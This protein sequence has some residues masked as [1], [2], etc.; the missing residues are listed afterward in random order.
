ME[1]EVFRIAP[2]APAKRDMP[3]TPVVITKLQHNA[4]DLLDASKSVAHDGAGA[5]SHFVGTTRD[6]FE[7]KRVLSLE[8]EAYDKMAVKEMERL[9]AAILAQWPDLKGIYIAHR[10]GSVPVGEASVIIAVSSP[11][12]RSAIGTSIAH[13]FSSQGSFSASLYNRIR[14]SQDVLTATNA[15]GMNSEPASSRRLLPCHRQAQSV[16]PNLEEGN[17]RRWLGVE[18]E[19]RV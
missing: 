8:Y 18:G 2:G 15:A 12:R 19:Q 9:C 11:H 13:A 7:G 14:L 10:L 5:I 1:A 4:L 3:N 17:V 16:R 6:N